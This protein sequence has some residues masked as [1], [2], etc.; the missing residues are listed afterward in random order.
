[1]FWSLQKKTTRFCTINPKDF[2][3]HIG[4]LLQQLMLCR[5]EYPHTINFRHQKHRRIIR[6]RENI[7]TAADHCQCTE[8]VPI[9]NNCFCAT[10]KNHHFVLESGWNVM[11]TLTI[12]VVWDGARSWL[13]LRSI[14]CGNWRSQAIDSRHL[15]KWRCGERWKRQTCLVWRCSRGLFLGLAKIVY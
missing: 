7:S 10:P 9:C 5:R 1:M 4:H 13:E 11:E 12:W 15:W 3:H 14:S 8:I 6:I 2:L